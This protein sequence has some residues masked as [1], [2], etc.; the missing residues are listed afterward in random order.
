MPG[1]I[2]A[3]EE[4]MSHRITDYCILRQSIVDV[5]MDHVDSPKEWLDTGC[6]AG[7]SAR[8]SLDTF[9]DTHFILAD[10]SEENLSEA[11]RTIGRDNVDF[12]CSPTHQLELESSSLDV[13]TAILSHHYYADIVSKKE[14][15]SNCYRMLKDGGVYVMVEHTVYDDA[16]NRMDAEWR[17]YME[18]NGLDAES[19]QNMFDRR[20]TFYFPLTESQHIKLLKEIGFSEIEVFWNSCSDIGICARK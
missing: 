8:L 3:Q 7:G 19:I 9:K 17:L 18:S 5:I 11:K 1:H 14:A 16:Q 13:I 6:G 15:I 10:P 2:T 20:N 12:I 4:G